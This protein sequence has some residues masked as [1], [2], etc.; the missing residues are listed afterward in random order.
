MQTSGGGGA[1]VL[2]RGEGAAERRG[3][4]ERLRAGWLGAYGR[5]A[6][7]RLR[8]GGGL[9][10][11]DLPRALVTVSPICWAGGGFP[12]EPGPPPPGH[13]ELKRGRATRRQVDGGGGWA[14]LAARQA[15]AGEGRSTAAAFGQL[16]SSAEHRGWPRGGDML[17]FRDNS[18]YQSGN[19]DVVR[20]RQRDRQ[21]EKERAGTGRPS[22]TVPLSFPPRLHNSLDGQMG[23][24]LVHAGRAAGGEWAVRRPWWP[25]SGPCWGRGYVSK[26]A[27]G[28]R[29]AAPSWPCPCPLGTRRSLQGRGQRPRSHRVGCGHSAWRACWG[30]GPPARS[31]RLKKVV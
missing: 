28:G 3:A 15:A 12:S 24:A 14:G 8:P 26:A 19:S 16:V 27:R 29:R 25:L 31:S 13:A 22:R 6:H 20:D 1:K 18:W 17:T 11:L 7:H 4:E 5:F 23:A 9:G 21:R 2:G 10:R 30:P